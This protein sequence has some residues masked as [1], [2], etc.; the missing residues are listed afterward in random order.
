MG[1]VVAVAGQNAKAPAT[2]WSHEAT[3]LEDSMNALIPIAGL[4]VVAAMTPGP[5]N[6]V[7]LRAAA[8]SGMVAAI[9]AIAGIV[10][11]GLALVGLVAAGAGAALSAEPRLQTVM[12]LS[13]CLYLAW[14]G[15]RLVVRAGPPAGPE[16]S[17]GRPLPAGAVALFGFQFLNPK[18]WMM[19]LTAT[20]APGVT[21]WQLAA[22]FAIIPPVCLALWS[23]GGAA[24]S[25]HLGRPRVATWFDRAMG[26]LL[27][28]CAAALGAEA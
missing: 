8:R 5:N 27:L 20:A 12:A 4:V 21:F 28:A 9:P 16:A 25:G 26:I 13:G 10:T 1:I 23:A 18:A 14:L 22:L 24:L 3:D 11:G 6:L 17:A 19:V 7:V 2:S 15:L